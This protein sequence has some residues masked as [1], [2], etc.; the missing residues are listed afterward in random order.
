MESLNLIDDI[1]STKEDTEKL[2]FI[3]FEIQNFF[4]KECLSPSLI[5]SERQ[6]IQP[7]ANIMVDYVTILSKQISKLAE[8]IE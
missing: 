1:N 7:L 4:H 5:E 2:K 3:A 6:R 8:K